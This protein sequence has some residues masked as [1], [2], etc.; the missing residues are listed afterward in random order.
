MKIDLVVPL[1]KTKMKL[2][3]KIFLSLFRPGIWESKKKRYDVLLFCHDHDRGYKFNNKAYAQLTDSLCDIFKE[4]GL[5]VISIATP[6]SQVTGRLAYNNPKNI[7]RQF[8]WSGITDKLLSLC[9]IERLCA[10]KYKDRVEK[11]WIKILSTNSPR[12]IIAIQPT[13]KLCRASHSLR[14]P[15]Y[16]LQHGVISDSHPS[17]GEVFKKEA[18]PK[19]LPTGFLCWD[20]SSANALD[21]W[22][23]NKG[24]KVLIIG[25]PWFKRFFERSKCDALVQKSN[26]VPIFKNRNKNILVSLQWN[27]NNFYPEQIN[28]GVMPTCIERVIEKTHNHFN[29]LIRLHPVQIFNGEKKHVEKYLYDKFGTFVNVDWVLST[30]Y[31]LPVIL[32]YTTLHI[33][34]WST[35]T[36]EASLFG[37][38]TALLDTEMRT[39][40]KRYADYLEERNL[41]IADVIDLKEESIINW[42]MANVEKIRLCHHN[43]KENL[44]YDELFNVLTESK[45]SVI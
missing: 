26:Y 10:R 38:P 3:H 33:T 28:N 39:K 1:I 32:T 35:V 18:N 20:T 40:G 15:I 7:N 13:Y 43:S 30:N 6:F 31:P 34:C 16:D 9:K 36:K 4:R 2:L 37:I 12:L 14:I 45:V 19:D 21:K 41:G 11:L 27:M 24:C 5:S 25:N 29:W 23:T 42:L 8:L 44:N 17:Y 22:A